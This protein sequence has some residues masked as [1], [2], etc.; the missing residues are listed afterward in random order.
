MTPF[1]LPNP[2]EKITPVTDDALDN[3]PPGEWLTWR[4]T[5]DDHGF[6]PLKQIN[7][8][9]VGD[10]RVAWA[11]SLPP[12]QNEATPLEHDGVLFVDSFGDRVQ[13]LNAVTGDLLW[14]YSRQLPSDNRTSVKRNL[15]IYGDKLL[16]P[17]S[18]C[19]IVALDIRTGKVIWDTEIADYSK[20][21]QTTGGPLV[22][23]GK[24]MQ[25]IAGQ[26]AGGNVI[27]ALDVETGK[28]ALTNRAATA[29]TA[30]RLKNA[31]VR[32]CGPRVAM[33]GS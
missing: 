10:L 26:S 25:G 32:R 15:S 2:L 14:Q 24:V 5:Y 13:A 4:R 28:E 23:K 22:A 8:K 29:G 1:L 3:P 20:G 11:W 16:V 18:D 31:T 9:N 30:C 21:F 12:G 7:K 27:V 6:S 19:H 17:T 33:I